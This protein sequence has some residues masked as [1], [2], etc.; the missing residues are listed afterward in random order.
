MFM[1]TII[2]VI[3]VLI[4]IALSLIPEIWVFIAAFYFVNKVHNLQ[5][6]LNNN[7][8]KNTAN[9]TKKS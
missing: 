8:T 7:L 6:I 9:L 3:E 1:W 5:N 2:L 4:W